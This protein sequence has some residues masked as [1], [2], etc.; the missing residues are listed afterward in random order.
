[1]E[2]FLLRDDLLG[3]GLKA[4]CLC[5][6]G[7]SLGGIAFAPLEKSTGEFIKAHQHFL[8]VDLL[9]AYGLG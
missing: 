9:H 3:N 7:I 4:V 1:M 8:K 6:R 2:A 5:S